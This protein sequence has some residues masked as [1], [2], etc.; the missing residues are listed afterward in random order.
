MLLVIAALCG[1]CEALFT[2]MEVALGALSRARLRALAEQ[3]QEA[4][5]RDNQASYKSA[6]EASAAHSVQNLQQSTATHGSEKAVAAG[7]LGPKAA[8]VRSRPERL[9]ALLEHSDRLS[10]T[11]III[12]SLSLWTA[13]SLLTWQALRDGWSLWSL[14]AALAGLLFLAEALPL[15]IAAR[16]PEAIALRG[17]R[18]IERSVQVL[19]PLSW[20]LGGIGAGVARLFGASSH[21]RPQ[22]TEGELRHALDQAEQEGV[23]EPEERAM[24]ESAIDFRAKSV[25]DVMTARIDI[26]AV[27]ALM[28]LRAVLNVAMQQGHSR[29][30]VYEGST[31]HIVGIIAT[32]DLLQHLRPGA[33]ASAAN[34]NAREVARH[35]FFLPEGKRV[36]A[37]IDDLRRQRM[38]M[39]IVVE[40]DGGTAGVVTLE[41]LLE[42]IVGEIEDEYDDAESPLR[43]LEPIPEPNSEPNT[44][45][46]SQGAA[47][48][49]GIVADAS[50]TVRQAEKFWRRHFG[51]PLVLFGQ[52]T[53]SAS[54]AGASGAGASHSSTWS[55]ASESLSLAGLAQQ[56]FDG[57][58]EQGQSVRAG[59]IAPAGTAREAAAMAASGSEPAS[60]GAAIEM[61]ITRARGPRLEEVSL[62][63]GAAD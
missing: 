29:L 13:G 43:I 6:R 3:E 35:P 63:R 23:I 39:A 11:F 8:P 41:D 4:I 57:V 52:A 16:S 7:Q 15:V 34:L 61:Q 28:P 58:P 59:A 56:L 12:T 62:V 32:K 25:G 38:L 27:P 37:A 5:A 20:L 47:V 30:P 19:G 36:D 51:E 21:A 10:L 14:A 31:D 24:L 54:V 48:S 40:P 9:L 17:V 46:P 22:V 2:A 50:C 60:S 18:L 45:I 1:L 49:R 33:D 55:A 26:V 42:E 53:I 44:E